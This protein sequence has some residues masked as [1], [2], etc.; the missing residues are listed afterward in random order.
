MSC[1]ISRSGASLES[2]RYFTCWRRSDFGAVV[3]IG[4]PPLK[5]RESLGIAAYIAPHPDGVTDDR[6][7]VV[8]WPN[9]PPTQ[10]TFNTTMSNSRCA[11]GTGT[12][13]RHYLPHWESHARCHLIVRVSRYM[14]PGPRLGGYGPV[15]A[16]GDDSLNR[17]A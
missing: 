7:K 2:R 6:L 16:L 10:R 5:R 15:L 13:N 9:K 11:L 3:V 17:V 8:F 14:S 4:V 12:N 1:S